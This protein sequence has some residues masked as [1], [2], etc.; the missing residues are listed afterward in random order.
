M[1]NNLKMFI[2]GVVSNVLGWFIGIA[3]AIGIISIYLFLAR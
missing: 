3:L 1:S 2:A